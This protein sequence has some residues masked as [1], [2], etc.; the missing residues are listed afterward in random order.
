MTSLALTRFA[1]I[2]LEYPQLLRLAIPLIGAEL[3]WMLM[4]F[5]DL[6]MVGRVGSTALAAVSVGSA[7]FIMFAIIAEG[8]MMGLDALASQAYGA[9]RLDDCH[10]SLW[11]AL[12][13][14]APLALVMVAA[15]WASV[16]LLRVLKIP[17]DVCAQAGP[18]MHSIGWSLLP[19]IPYFALRRYLQAMHM[20]KIITFA[21]ISANI[22]NAFFNWVLIYGRLGFPAMGATG[23]GWSTTLARIYTMLVLSAYTAYQSRKRGFHLLSYAG[24]FQAKLMRELVR[25]GGPAAGQIALEVGVF[26]MCTLLIG[27]LGPVAVGGHQIAL[28]L[29]TCTFMVP[30]GI[31]SAT[32]VRVGNAIGRRDIGAAEVSGWTGVATSIS[33]MMCAALVFWLIPGT[34]VALFTN[35]AAVAATAVK[36]LAIAAVFQLFDGTQVTAIGAL[37]GSGDTRWAMVSNIV[38]W[39]MIGLPV[40]VYLC[41]NRGWGARGMWIGLCVGLILIGCVLAVAWRRRMAQMKRK[42]DTNSDLAEARQLL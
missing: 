19:L 38:G 9:G 22:I 28:S 12:Q 3:G 34:L 35:D 7:V 33:F 2:R 18:F 14:A 13:L 25:L 11:A 10:R 30:L 1:K 36:L 32:A 37:R 24:Y 8:L 23:S 20:V 17:A 15:M 21:M 26:S 16:P 39:W 40:G 29:I 6:A 5:V 31:S 4:N 41:F 27:R 42:L